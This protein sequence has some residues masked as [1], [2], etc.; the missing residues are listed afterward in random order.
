MNKAK[1]SKR[2]ILHLETRISIP[3]AQSEGSEAIKSMLKRLNDNKMLSIGINIVNRKI[4]QKKIKML[5]FASD[6]NPPELVEHLLM[7]AATMK[8]IFFRHN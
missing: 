7:M 3:K 5:V 4:I 2:Q 1:V 8:I 6:I